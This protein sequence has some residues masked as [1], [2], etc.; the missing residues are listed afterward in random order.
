MGIDGINDTLRSK[1]EGVINCLKQSGNNINEL[2]FHKGVNLANFAGTKMAF[3]ISILINAKMITAHNEILL[4]QSSMIGGYDRNILLNK[5]IKGILSFFGTIIANG[6]TPVIIFEGETHPYKQVEVDKRREKKKE[7]NQRTGNL[8]NNYMESHPLERTQAMEDE[9]KKSMKNSV[10]ITKDDI[11][12]IKRVLIGLGFSCIT[13][14]YDAEKLC[15]SLYKEGIVSSVYGNDTDNYPL[16][17]GVLVT[18]I[19]WDGKISV[20]DTVILDEIFKVL[21]CDFGYQVTPEILIDLCIIHGC[22]FNER[23]LIP[24]AKSNSENPYK[25]CGPVTGTEF[26]KQYRHFE[27][28][29]ASLQPFL[30]Q[31]NYHVGRYMFT[32]HNTS[33][34]DNETTNIDTDSFLRNYSSI[35]NEYNVD[36]YIVIQYNNANFNVLKG[37]NKL[38]FQNPMIDN[39]HHNTKIGIDMMSIY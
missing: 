5:A 9:I 37:N 38:N 17:T 14:P 39:G 11:N 31:L 3:D 23:M 25:S 15:A 30:P 8:I 29:P 10:R 28:F 4:S 7:K 1:A 34:Y 12:S 13:A 26:I 16:G 20:C 19:Y 36:R 32:H 6:I 33:G 22:D 18:K 21:S 27:Y 35:M 2:I 24:K